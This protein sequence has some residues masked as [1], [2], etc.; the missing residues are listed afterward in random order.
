MNYQLVTLSFF[1]TCVLSF[2]SAIACGPG[3]LQVKDTSST[4]AYST[5]G[6]PLTASG[7]T[8]GRCATAGD[9][10]PVAPVAT[11]DTKAA[12]TVPALTDATTVAKIKFGTNSATVGSKYQK[13]VE[14]AL[15]KIKKSGD[16]KEIEVVG[17][18]DERGT[19]THNLTLSEKRAEAVSKMLTGKLGTTVKTVGAG[20][21]SA[22][23]FADARV[24]EIKA[25]K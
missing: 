6:I 1:L 15:A 9:V 12:T 11:V 23:N 10:A 24:V 20:E 16:Y 4:R 5:D 22:K 2:N 7:P 17:F 8:T 21:K 14:S 18:A 25:V 13:A 19:E 3:K